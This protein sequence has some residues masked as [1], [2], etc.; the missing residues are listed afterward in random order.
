[1]IDVVIQDKPMALFRNAF[2]D[3]PSADR[4]RAEGFC[5]PEGMGPSPPAMDWD[6]TLIHTDKGISDS[7]VVVS[8]LVEFA[9]LALSCVAVVVAVGWGVDDPSMTTPPYESSLITD[10]HAFHRVPVA[11]LH[12]LHG[13][14]R[15]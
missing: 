2:R 3:E 7:G 6:H 8:V 12:R 9:A 14:H 10:G 5:V 11:N 4:N 13:R 1:M 15:A